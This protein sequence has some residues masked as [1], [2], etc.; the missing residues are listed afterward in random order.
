[1]KTR[2]L[3][4]LRHAA[5]LQAS[6]AT[7][8]IAVCLTDSATAASQ[9]WRAAPV[10]STWAGT[11]N[12]GA[13][14]T[15]TPP[16]AIA[17][18][19][20]TV[21]SNADI[22]TFNTA[23]AGG[24]IGSITDPINNE[25][26]RY[27]RSVLFDTA[28]VG[29]YVIGT[30]GGNAFWVGH[31]GNV[32]VGANVT[33]PQVINA[34]TNIRLPSSTNGVFSFVNNSSTP[35]ATLT[36]PLVQSGSANTRPI[37]I[38]LNGSNTGNNTIGSLTD[39]GAV[40]V[41]KEGAGTWILSGASTITSQTDVGVV[42]GARVNAGTLIVQNAASLG[43]AAN[44]VTVNGGT[45]QLD[46]IVLNTNAVTLNGGAIKSNGTST[47]NGVTVG[48]AATA[49]T[50]STTASGDIFT[51]GN[52]ANKLTGTN[53]ASVISADG[54]GTISLPNTSNYAGSWSLN[55]GT[56]LLGNNSALGA[57]AT[58]GVSFG[59][60]STTLLKLNGFSSTITSLSTNATPG[61]PVVENGTSGTSLLTVNNAT[62]N[63]FAGALNDGAA[64]VLALTKGGAGTLTLDGANGYTGATIIGAGA[65]KINSSAATA[66]VAV[67]SGSTLGGIGTIAGAVTVASTS[68]LAPGNG[69]GTLTMGSLT[70]SSG[71]IVDCE[72]KTGPDANDL[73]VVTTSDGLT[74]NG[75]G[76]NLYQEGTTTQFNTIGTYD[77]IS[78]T[79][80]TVIPTTNLS[81][82]NPDP[83]KN[84]AFTSD[85][86][87][88][89]L[90]ISPSVISDWALASGGDWNTGANW[91][92]AG[93]PD[94]SGSTAIF[95]SALTASG[96]V[97]L[98]GDRTVSTL[99]FDNANSYTIEAASTE[100]LY[101]DNTA[102]LGQ[103]QIIGTNGSHQITA[104]IV[105]NSNTVASVANSADTIS[106]TGI[107]SGTG[108]L[109]KSGGGILHL[110]GVNTY[111][112][113][114]TIGNGTLSFGTGGISTAGSIALSTATLKWASGN[115]D[116]ISLATAVS[117][118]AGNAIFDTNGND[119][120]F[121]AGIGNSGTGSLVK[122]G[123][124]KLSLAG[125]NSYSGSTTITAGTL[126][127][128][129][130]NALG[131][132]PGFATPGSLSIGAAALQTT[133]TFAI[134]ANRGIALTSAS[135]TINTDTSTILTV[136]GIIAGGG[137]LNL[138]GAGTL[139]LTNT[140]T[141]SG[142]TYL[143]PGTTLNLSGV[144]TTGSGLVTLEGGTLKLNRNLY[145]QG[146]IFVDAAQT[147]TL[148]GVND[149]VG[150]GGLTGSGTITLISRFGGANVTSGANGFRLVAGNGGFTGTINLQSGTA[151]TV[152]SFAAYFN[153]GGFDGNF[154]GA[155]V[156]MS[157]Y[158]RIGGVNNS[159]GN[160]MTIGAL[161]G[162]STTILAGADYAG[163]H[164]YNIGG[165]NL[166]TSF[167]GIVA[168][169]SAGNANLIKSGTGTFTLTGTNTYFGTTTVNAGTL[170]ITNASALGSDTVGTTI[171][172][173][174]TNARVTV[175]G[176]LTVT[177]P[178]TLAGR[179]GVNADSPSIVSLSGNN[180]LSGLVSPVTS[181][182][183]YSVESVSGNLTLSGNFVPAGAVTGNRNLQILG[184]GTSEWSGTILNGTAIVSVNIRGAGIKTL[185]GLNTYTGDT[186]V[187]AASSLI[188]TSSSETKFSPGAPG[189]SNKITGT[190]AVT[191]DGALNIDLTAANILNGNSW[192]LVDVTNLTETYG[193]NFTVPG[194][195]QSGTNWTKLDGANTW[196]FSQTTGLLTLAVVTDPFVTWAATYF[197]TET[198]PAIIGKAADPDNDG[199]N[200]LAEFA[201]NSAPN[202]S[203][204]AGKIVGKVAT[205]GSNDV[206]TLTLPVRNGA[207]FTDD[208]TTHEEVSALTDGLIYR[209]Q[210][211]TD[212][213][214]WTLDVSEVA[215]GAERD[216]IQLG[217][218][219]LDTGWTYRTFRA[220]GSVSSSASDFLRVKVTE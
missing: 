99:S 189:T 96:A 88:V 171:I 34:P 20:G 219:A 175:E 190:G 215:A 114:T 23:L 160:T 2:P 59:A 12:W 17:P 174:D 127:I 211:T 186:N 4:G 7:L 198:N 36:L 144:G 182:S 197:G 212:L 67:N 79:G 126:S 158:A 201:L 57:P 108:S 134:N 87:S 159:G 85:A 140:N 40:L 188:L 55:S 119:V 217:L 170:A 146:N 1:M 148:D 139:D 118:P 28:S 216:A 141:Y 196:T 168:N 135:S 5:S 27:V 161:S 109:S 110:G 15:V 33:N 72:F 194:F 205:V 218:P 46:G 56:V 133:G 30:A 185:S 143:P 53:T 151:S 203:T 51:V 192:L 24:T 163:T 82:L 147:G 191:L 86:T 131:T 62:A 35:T 45:L 121:T 95:G 130:D 63:T 162:D 103:A 154:S 26:Q 180:V 73:A 181:G 14:G 128:G 187:D 83:T 102:N 47:V 6:L 123:A 74:L 77:L 166:D 111:S 31:N 165:K 93:I 177:E 75:G 120:V 61:T 101:L 207:T 80:T 176:G 200:N 22:A 136:N 156:N 124:G 178:W 92:G 70:L 145:T 50:L 155:T 71:A 129:A 41:I 104:P 58:T 132:V 90:T 107:I 42:S 152:N 39:S 117:L 202:S 179:Q 125:G 220:P 137:K 37:S 149:R 19:A 169:G 16:G 8:F 48:A 98:N 210:G 9:T 68:H 193:S 21:G 172:G 164:T 66:S 3:F 122:S 204:N 183:N 209:I 105:L 84:Y 69:V 64:G 52:A 60:S 115:T 32:T 173:G 195:T 18:N 214:A 13:T 112:G 94:A 116:D 100:S 106:L 150:L 138:N 44:T 89:K 157:N 206:L 10:D 49:V 65:L 91:T 76:F 213:S 25:N 199:L 54:P 11:S 142:G 78:Y 29:S 208:L 113:G 38:T 81:V 97:I 167:D 184:A 43:V 153:G